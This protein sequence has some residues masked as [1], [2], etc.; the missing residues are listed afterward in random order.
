MPN[1]SKGFPYPTSSDD[2]NVP[3]DIQL[4]AQA[5]DTSLNNYSQTT[6]T[7]TG[8]YATTTHT[9]DGVYANT[10]HTHT[11]YLEPSDL[12]GYSQN[13]H[14]HDTLYSGL[15]H[16]HT[17]Y[18]NTS[19]I[20]GVKG[21]IPIGTAGG[22]SI[23]TPGTNDYVLVSDSTT[24]TGTKWANVAAV[25]T[26]VPNTFSNI[27]VSGQTTVS[28][29]STVDTLNLTAGSNVTITTD[30]LTDTIT[31]SATGGDLSGHLAAADP[32][33]QYLTQSE[34]DILYDADGSAAAAQ[35]AANIYTDTAIS[36]LVNSAPAA[37]NTLK[38]LSDA[39]GGD[40]LF[41]TTVT[42]A[43]ASKAPINSPSFTGTVNFSGATITG[44]NPF[45]TQT[46]NGGKYLT[47][48]GTSTSWGTIDL[49]PYL[50]IS[51]AAST[52]LNTT[53]ASNVYAPKA[54]PSFTGTVDFTGATSVVGLS[55]ILPSQSGNSG[56]FLGTNGSTAQWASIS[57]VP[58]QTDNSVKYLTTD[59]TTASW[60]TVSS[61]P[62][63]G[64]ITSAMILNETIVDSDISLSAAID[65]SKI[66][67]IAVTQ[68][69]VGT[70]T[71]VM[72][73]GTITN[74]KL[75]NSSI[76]INGNSVALGASTTIDA[77]PS[78][79]NNSGKYLT[80]NG[81]SAS[82]ATLT[83]NNYSNGTNTS[84]ANKIFYN[85]TGSFPT[86]TAAGDIYIQY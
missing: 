72:L 64:S 60:A 28:A 40:A 23:I 26:V 74:N 14:T 50:T 43:L 33:P 80:T 52:Y 1:T 3:Q 54:S 65:K 71:N 51:S 73:A 59:G 62:A 66:S 21:A 49:T 41:A 18:L 85:N 47:T 29:D 34:A 4:L 37:L 82:W 77:L 22:V 78:Q 69:D 58:D 27:A 31:I 45:P 25:G 5:V 6:H 81:S 16:V 12:A 79:L 2:P 42:N 53:T 56:K 11:E 30:P 46:G 24:A 76:T 57:Q 86:A 13:T 75:A 35:S 55:S 39:L 63:E 38:E 67:G 7:H 9:H 17:D 32:H 20:S 10:T 15:S 8:V 44:Y 19:A 83:T 84:T 48:N 61:T 36:N 68:S 70:V